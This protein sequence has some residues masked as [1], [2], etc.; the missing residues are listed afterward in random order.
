MTSLA[1]LK[2][3]LLQ[4]PQVRAAYERDALPPR[5]RAALWAFRAQAAAAMMPEG[6]S[7][8]AAVASAQDR[9]EELQVEVFH[10]SQVV[11][12]Q[13]HGA[14]SVYE[15]SEERLAELLGFSSREEGQ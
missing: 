9:L 15:I 2:E 11:D 12:A 13:P 3:R 5:Y 14:A 7:R 4:N 1:D 6:D 8:S 10:I